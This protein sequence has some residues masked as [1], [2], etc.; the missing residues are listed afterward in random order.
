V[1]KI[2]PRGMYT[3]GTG[4]SAVGLTAYIT[5]DPE[6]RENVLESGALVL[7]DRGVCCIDEFDKMT[8]STRSI[9]HEVMEQQTVSIAKAGIICTLNARTS[10]LA[11]AN[12]VE[13][14]YN[15]RL[16]V[17]ENIQLPPTLLSRFDLIYLILD[18]VSPE[19]DRRLARHLISL[20]WAQGVRESEGARAGGGAA[21]P[22]R[23]GAAPSAANGGEGLFERAQLMEYIGYAKEALQP[24]LSDAAKEALVQGYLDMRRQGSRGG[25]GRKTISATT[26]QLESLVRLSEAHA[27]MRL[28][29]EVLPVDV[30]EAIRLMNVAT[31][32]AAVDPRTGTIDMSLIAS[33]QTGDQADAAIL[34]A[35]EIREVVED[36]A[37]SLGGGGGGAGGA[38]AGAASARKGGRTLTLAELSKRLDAAA[39]S[40]GLTPASGARPLQ[41]VQEAVRLLAREDGALIELLPENRFRVL[42]RAG[43][44]AARAA[45]D[46]APVQGDEVAEEDA[47]PDGY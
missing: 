11:S 42:P 6:S 41:L 5:K 4:S 18:A 32:R 46:G 3:S 44:G 1:H 28:S 2:A 29:D 22:G 43:R 34:L 39:A 15:P 7:S 23:G 37:V 8:D 13:S 36:R 47:G 38:G 14:R 21:G 20:H 26:R 35:E 31:Q 30:A 25:G 27:R 16:S 9:L 17:V 40:G 33:G 19:S 45:A 10:V 12:P 24:Q